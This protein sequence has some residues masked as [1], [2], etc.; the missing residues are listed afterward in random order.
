MINDKFQSKRIYLPF[1]YF[2]RNP[3]ALNWGT[4][5]QRAKLLN[6]NK[7]RAY[8]SFETCESN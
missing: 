1:R 8:V 2:T 7:L 6:G 5:M 4:I 3:G